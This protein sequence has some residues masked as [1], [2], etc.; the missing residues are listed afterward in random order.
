[1]LRSALSAISRTAHRAAG[2]PVERF[3]PASQL[4]PVANQTGVPEI[5]RKFSTEAAAPK[6]PHAEFIFS[7]L[8][9]TKYVN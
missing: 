9:D 7:R 2:A 4:L 6:K 1:M 5:E 3:F 8:G